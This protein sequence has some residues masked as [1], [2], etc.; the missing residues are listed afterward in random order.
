MLT[1]CSW[2]NSSSFFVDNLSQH[3]WFLRI[4]TTNHFGHLGV[5]FDNTNCVR[6]THLAWKL[7]HLPDHVETTVFFHGDVV[8]HV[9]TRRYLQLLPQLKHFQRIFCGPFLLRQSGRC[10]NICNLWCTYHKD[11]SIWDKWTVGACS[12][13]LHFPIFTQKIACL[14]SVFCRLSKISKQARFSGPTILMW[15]DFKEIRV[16]LCLGVQVGTLVSTT[17]GTDLGLFRLAGLQ[18]TSHRNNFNKTNS[19]RCYLGKL[20]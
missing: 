5:K 13:W 20:L 14:D 6:P 9:K 3:V 15:T 1:V 10:C 11:C 19:Q 18:K 2:A 7:L 8:G 4:G 12:A 16:G 17:N